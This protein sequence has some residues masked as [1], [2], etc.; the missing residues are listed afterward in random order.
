LT[1]DGETVEGARRGVEIGRSSGPGRG[2]ESGVDD[3]G[4]DLDTGV[5]DLRIAGRQVS[6]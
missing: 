1:V 4:E 2:E 5:L 6:D 3:R